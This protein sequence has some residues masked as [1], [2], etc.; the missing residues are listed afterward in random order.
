MDAV[1]AGHD[2][3]VQMIDSSSVR[4]H[5]HAANTKKRSRSLYGRSR[6]RRMTKIHALTDANGLPL[7]LVLTPGQAADRPSA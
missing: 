3:Q 1:T 6:G 5:Q 2:G 4:V 7:E